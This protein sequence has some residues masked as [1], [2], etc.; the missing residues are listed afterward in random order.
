MSARRISNII[1]VMI[2]CFVIPTFFY[3]A[4]YDLKARPGENDSNHSKQQFNENNR[5]NIPFAAEYLLK[6]IYEDSRSS[7]DENKRNSI[8]VFFKTAQLM[9]SNTQGEAEKILN[10]ATST[11]AKK[12][13][14]LYSVYEIADSLSENE[15]FV[16]IIDD[17][18]DQLQR[19]M[20]VLHVTRSSVELVKAKSSREEIERS[21]QALR[22]GL[23][24]REWY[25]HKDRCAEIF[26]NTP[27]NVS[28]ETLPFDLEL[29]NDLYKEIFS[30]LLLNKS[31]QE[32]H[33]VLTGPLVVLPMNVLVTEA[34]QSYVDSEWFVDRFIHTMNAS[35]DN[36]MS[37]MQRDERALDARRKMRFLGV[38]NPNLE[39]DQSS[40]FYSSRLR[41]AARMSRSFTS[42]ITGKLFGFGSVGHFIYSDTRNSEIEFD[43][44]GIAL[45][46]SI[47][48]L[49]P[50]PESAY[51]ICS[52]SDSFKTL[53]KRMLLSKYAREQTVKELSEKGDLSKYDII[54]IASH[55]IVDRLGKS[56]G[57]GIVLSPQNT[58]TLVD[59]GFLSAVEIAKLKLDAEWVIL[60]ACNT[61]TA[62]R[63]TN[64]LL[65]G[66]AE[67]FS[68]ANARSL[69]VTNWS[70]SSEA[71]MSLTIKTVR[72]YVDDMLAKH[73]AL[74]ESILE[75]KSGT[76]VESHPAF[77]G[78]FILIGS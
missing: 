1:S 45:P 47:K 2:T 11:N 31:G 76:G 18:Y 67:A 51:E 12:N 38:G 36:Y 56:S 3:F 28:V 14:V 48:R 60:S 77:W 55:A 22:C 23:D 52:V 72:K 33:I 37:S 53:E 44:N 32:L 43:D 68:L 34:R 62:G 75:L 46:S 29:S 4:I 58:S 24:V 30:S 78:P 15:E 8:D 41:K 65:G 42:C 40:I 49:M 39:G 26:P 64:K 7:S 21:V 63:N 71:A 27:D 54:H 10:I 74:R 50:L 17:E 25:V 5:P 69:L 13:S 35:V 9:H 66:L 57:T 70:V 59:D 19:S 16:Y 20:Y 6:D 73:I 61:G